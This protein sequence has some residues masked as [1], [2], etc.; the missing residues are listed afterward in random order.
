M[1][2]PHHG[3]PH[4]QSEA[5]QSVRLTKRDICSLPEKREILGGKSRV[6]AILQ[7]M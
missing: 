6:D 4:Y 5:E 3:S 2:A 7:A 1:M